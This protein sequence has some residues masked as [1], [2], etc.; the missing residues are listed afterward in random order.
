MQAPMRFTYEAHPARVVFA[1][2]SLGTIAGEVD[3]L[4]GTRVMVIA[5]ARLAPRVVELLGP[6]VVSTTTAAVVHVPADL[7]ADAL[8]TAR[9]CHADALVTVGGGSPIGLGKAIA[10]ET[11]LPILAVPTT[12]AGSEMTSVWGLSEGGIKRTGRDPRVRPR[13]AVYDPELTASLPRGVAGPSG[14]NAI[15][16]AVEATYAPAVDPVTQLLAEEA[17]RTMARW[18]PRIA[19]E[20]GGDDEGARGG[21]LYAAWLAGVCLDRATMG[22]HHKLC[23]VLGGAFGLQHA[24]LHA[25]IL[26]YAA[27]FNRDA[28]PEAMRRLSRALSTDDVPSALHALAKQVGAPVSLASLGMRREDLDHAAELATKNPYDNPRPVDRAGVR[29]LLESAF[30]GRPP[31]G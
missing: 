13:T 31:A 7:A 28:A 22:I 12:Y 23:H 1:A 4:G 29:A 30:D 9:N 18:L 11:G 20:P 14:L 5:S 19:G 2:G 21:C 15:A 6:R 16:H 24:S 17:V 25:V 27:A 3:R 8:A 10:R 26:P